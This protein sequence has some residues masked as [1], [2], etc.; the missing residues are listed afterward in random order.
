[1][2]ANL[3][4]ILGK[5]LFKFRCRSSMQIIV[6]C[7]EVP[8][9]ANSLLHADTE[10]VEKVFQSAFFLNFLCLLMGPI[11]DCPGQ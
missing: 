8:V 2:K 11:A 6:L 1:M 7:S 10:K 9:T 3:V 5:A 4:L